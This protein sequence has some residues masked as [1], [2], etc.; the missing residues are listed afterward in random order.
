MIIEL[1]AFTTRAPGA[2]AATTSL[3]PLSPRSANTS[4]GLYALN[5]F[6]A[7]MR[8]RPF[9][10]GRSRSASSTFGQGTANRTYSRLAASAIVAG[11]A[12][13]PRSAANFAREGGARLLLNTT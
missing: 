13:V 11:D 4:L 7:S 9:H 2:N 10:G 3:A 8:T 5:G 6:V 1:N 12:P